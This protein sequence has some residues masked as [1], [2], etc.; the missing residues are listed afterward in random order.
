MEWFLMKIL[1]LTIEN[2]NSE[3]VRKLN[4][5]ETGTSVI[6]GKITKPNENRETSNSIGK[7]L[8]LKFVDYIFGANEDKTVVKEE[9]NGWKLI[10][11]VKYENEE[12]N[13]TRKLGSSD[14]EIN[15][16]LNSLKDYKSFFS[17]DRNLYN[18]QIFIKQ[19]SH[20]ISSRP[21]P[22]L[23]DYVSYFSLL[24]L[25]DLANL[26]RKYYEIQDKLKYLKK[27]EKEVTSIFGDI[28]P[29]EINEKIFLTNQNVL[30]KEEEIKK[31]NQKISSIEIS[32]EKLELVKNYSDKNYELK[33]IKSSFESVKLEIIRLKEFIE[34][35]NQVDISHSQINLLFKKAEVDIPEM[36]IKRFKDVE[37]FYNTV[38]IDRKNTLQMKIEELQIK[39]EELKSE[40]T[41]RSAKIDEIAKII[42]VN[43]IFQ[44]AIKIYEAKSLEL[45]QLKYNQGDLARIEEAIKNREAKEL[46][47]TDAYTEVKQEFDKY[48]ELVQKYQ[49]FI[50]STVKDIYTEQVT[51]F[52]SLELKKKHQ[53][54]RPFKM[55][56]NLKGDGG[57]GVG[58]VKKLIVDLLVFKY[59][60][61][62]EL[63]VHDS[64]C[65]SGGIDN[66][67]IASIIKISNDIAIKENKQ[68]ILSVND[69]QIKKD[70]EELMSILSN[71]VIELAEDDKLLRFTLKE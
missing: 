53:K 42:S 30:E 49:K 7:T 8:L 32:E 23:E 68:F 37:D 33:K 60:S 29:K 69:F 46:K 54:N 31:L 61:L 28:K 45:Q 2:P 36:V 58:E 40:I 56:L 20:I 52:F 59:N 19:K 57:E 50:Y 66:R 35:S 1:N 25:Y 41:F 62:L 5:S 3:K 34:E 9:I 71:R 11:I 48:E 38:F 65:Y 27:I 24:S 47:L 16:K 63:L 55:E 64:S 26:T 6:Y 4:F 22:T 44:E 14:M 70:D 12:F 39:Q 21:E 13:V 10:A 18:K 51:A 67:Q 43:K 17:I 15:G